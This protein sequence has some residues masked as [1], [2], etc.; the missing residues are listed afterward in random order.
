ME[1]IIEIDKIEDAS[2]KEWQ[3]STLKPMGIHFHTIE[4][5][6][7]LDE[8]N[9]DL[10]EGNAEIEDGKFISAKDLKEE[11]KKW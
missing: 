2:K 4:R 3:L 9:F 6:Q 1:L 7:N 10:E 8:Y 11:A 5:P